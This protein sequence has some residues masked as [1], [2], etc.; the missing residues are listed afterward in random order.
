MFTKLESLQVTW[1]GVSGDEEPLQVWL[2][3]AKD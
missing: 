3:E 1:L 2:S